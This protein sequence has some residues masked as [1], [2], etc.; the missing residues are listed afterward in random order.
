MPQ[1][2]WYGL[3]PDGTPL[4]SRVFA[5]SPE[6]V[7]EMSFPVV[8][9][10]R[11]V[12][13]KAPFLRIG[14]RRIMFMRHL[15]DLLDGGA[16]VLEALTV[17]AQ[18]SVDPLSRAWASDLAMQIQG[19]TSLAY[20]V[21]QWSELADP[22][23]IAAIEL[24]ER[25][26]MLSQSLMG[27]IW[28]S[29]M[30]NE[31]IRSA[32]RSVTLPLVAGLCALLVAMLFVVTIRPQYQ[33]LIDSLPAGKAAHMPFIMGSFSSYKVGVIIA[34]AGFVGWL[35]MLKRQSLRAYIPALF[36][37][38]EAL[39]LVRFSTLITQRY[40]LGESLIRASQASASA[41]IRAWGAR[42]GAII[43]AGGSFPALCGDAPLSSETR[44][45]L[46]LGERSG[47]LAHWSS[48]AAMRARDTALVAAKRL[49]S[50][51]VGLLLLSV[52][53]LI[54]AVIYA[55]YQPIIVLMQAV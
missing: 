21:S 47:T 23:L 39:F 34:V 30:H 33:A 40:G 49:S 43:E 24:G 6:H 3:S 35:F 27:F 51:V 50:L 15:A 5:R 2:K 12:L 52:G 42:A 22:Q 14:V 7:R 36:A 53:L 41:G 31:L 26:G 20:A 54:A 10:V 46:L 38:D 17:L 29:E 32:R 9:V 4:S 55:L 16:F 28:L 44:S 25:T 1:F 48:K 45:L 8:A 11:I 19:G 13:V 18:S 37:Y